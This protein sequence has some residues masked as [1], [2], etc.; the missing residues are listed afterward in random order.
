MRLEGGLH[1]G[2]SSS[3]VVHARGVDSNDH[4]ELLY[5]LG[6]FFSCDVCGSPLSLS[7]IPVAEQLLLVV[8]LVFGAELKESI[9]TRSVA[10]YWTFGL[11]FLVELDSNQQA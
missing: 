2:L 6:G 5:D 8:R 10:R 3:H 7:A 9:P 1:E 11:S 4:A